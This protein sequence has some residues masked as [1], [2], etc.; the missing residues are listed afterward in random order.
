MMAKGSFIRVSP[1]DQKVSHLPDVP[2]ATVLAY[3]KGGKPEYVEVLKGLKPGTRIFDQPSGY[4]IVPEDL[5]VPTNE[6]GLF[7]LHREADILWTAGSFRKSVQTPWSRN[8]FTCILALALPAGSVWLLLLGTQRQWVRHNLVQM[9]AKLFG[10]EPV[11]EKTVGGLAA[12]L[13]NHVGGLFHRTP[14][15]AGVLGALMLLTALFP[16]AV[17]IVSYP[18]GWVRIAL[19]VLGTMLLRGRRMSRISTVSKKK[20]S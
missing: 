4:I 7:C 19:G 16:A 10:P 11:S 15:V 12:W 2:L 9:R 18:T 17:G 13:K 8:R 14:G 3:A 6:P 5:I 1:A 20:S